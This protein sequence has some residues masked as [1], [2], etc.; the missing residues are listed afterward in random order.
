MDASITEGLATISERLIETRSL[1]FKRYLYGDINFDARLIIIKGFRGVGKTTML[2]QAIKEAASTTKVIYLSLDHIYFTEYRLI[3][4]F[5]AYY[6]KGYRSFVMDEVHKY[7]DW[8][9]ELK[10][11]YDSYPDA[12]VFVTASSALKIIAGSADLSRRADIYHLKGMSFR[13]YLSFS[14]DITLT[15]YT[16]DD[17]VEKY[18]EIHETYHNTFD[19]TR[20][21]GKYLKGGYYPYFKEAGTKYYDR[22][23]STINQVIEIDM[24]AIFNIE[25]ETTRQIKRLLAMLSRLAPYTPNITQL[26]RDLKMSRTNVLEYLDYLESADLIHILK[27]NAKSDSVLTKPDKVFLDNTNLIYALG[28][29]QE[30][31]GMI[32]ETFAMN[33]LSVNNKVSTPARGD[34]LVDDKYTIE[35]G[36]P[37]KTFHQISDMANPILIKEGIEKGAKGILPMWML[38]LLW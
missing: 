37:K 30:N 34:L 18:E 27:S 13:E 9:I 21:F 5:D 11:L 25:Y 19:I 31:T 6:M 26:A 2:M 38:G 33:A 20:R 15:M 7:P 36:G 28:F 3:H 10:N 4:I 17:L 29:G 8:S 35:I 24:P 22:V 12:K 14:D 23:T 16:F 1:D 32:R